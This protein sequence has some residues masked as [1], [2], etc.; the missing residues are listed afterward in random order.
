MG[1]G[2]LTRAGTD[3]REQL[4]EKLNCL[5]G[6]ANIR[7][8]RVYRVDDHIQRSDWCYKKETSVRQLDGLV[9]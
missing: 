2:V 7:S 3:P 6:G 5:R 1:D 9:R 8:E 4:T